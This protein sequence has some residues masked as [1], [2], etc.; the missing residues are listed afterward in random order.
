[1][2]TEHINYIQLE[3]SGKVINNDSNKWKVVVFKKKCGCVMAERRPKNLTAGQ[4]TISKNSP[5]R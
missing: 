4:C 5:H 1:M 3:F 2:F